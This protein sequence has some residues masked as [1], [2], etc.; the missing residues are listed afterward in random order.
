MD[1]YFVGLLTWWA[2]QSASAFWV[3]I[4][5]RLRNNLARQDETFPYCV[6]TQIAGMPE[7]FQDDGNDE[8]YLMQNQ[9]DI[10]SETNS[11]VLQLSTKAMALLDDATFSITGWS[12]MKFERTRNVLMPRNIFEEV[13]HDFISHRYLIT[14]DVWLQKDRA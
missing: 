8:L 14:Y 11:E 3:G 1:A 12:I 13:E 10:Y 4:G 5:G 9:F 2:T 7:Y 6:F